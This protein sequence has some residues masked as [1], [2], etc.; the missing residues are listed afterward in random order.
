[1]AKKMKSYR[2]EEE[3]LDMLETLK[4]FLS[5]EKS[6]KLNDTMVIEMLISERYKKMMEEK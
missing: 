5:S 2:L 1:M 3:V 4:V 6:I